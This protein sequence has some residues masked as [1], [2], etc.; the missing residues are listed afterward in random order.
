VLY[1]LLDEVLDQGALSRTL[2]RAVQEAVADLGSPEDQRVAQERLEEELRAVD[3]QLA[4]LVAGLAATGGSATILA[5]IKEAERR[6]PALQAARDGLQA[7]VPALTPEEMAELE[8]ALRQQFGD[9]QDYCLSPGAIPA[10]RNILKS[11]LRGRLQFKML[12]RGAATF[13]GEVAVDGVFNAA[14]RNL[15]LTGELEAEVTQKGTTLYVPLPMPPPR[16]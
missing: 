12:G 13:T 6:K 7:A 5:A 4:N 8:A 9:W 1:A 14:R 10:C 15:T 16:T 3:G 2:H 11:V